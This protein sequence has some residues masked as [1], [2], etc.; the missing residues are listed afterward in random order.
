M[1]LKSVPRNLKHSDWL[2]PLAQHVLVQGYYVTEPQVRR[3]VVSCKFINILVC[4][5]RDLSRE[6]CR[7]INRTM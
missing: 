6:T 2:H 1:L 3:G 7:Y 4:N 5:E